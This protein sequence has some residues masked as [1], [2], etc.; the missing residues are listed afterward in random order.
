MVEKR[1]DLRRGDWIK[2]NILGENPITYAKV[3]STHIEKVFD[4]V[5]KYYN[6]NVLNPSKY[7]SRKDKFYKGSTADEEC[8]I[9]NGTDELK[10]ALLEYY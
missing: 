6:L 5:Y 1:R 3:V 8:I 9:I 4:I 7:W 2:I 10:L